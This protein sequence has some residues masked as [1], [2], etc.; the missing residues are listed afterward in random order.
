MTR[1]VVTYCDK[2]IAPACPGHSAVDK[3]PNCVTQ[4]CWQYPDE[5]TG[6]V[7]GFGYFV[8]LII[9][10]KDETTSAGILI[11]AGTYLVIRETDAGHIYVT[12]FDSADQAQAAFD[13][14]EA[15]YGAY[16]HGEDLKETSIMA[17]SGRIGR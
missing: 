15:L 17:S 13:E 16:C 10:P 2:A 14:W 1:Y 5:V 4:E 3:W 7:D 9:Q 6:N 12:A 11:K 8:A